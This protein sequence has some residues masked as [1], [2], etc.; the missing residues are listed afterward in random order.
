MMRDSR[1]MFSVFDQQR[2]EIILCQIC[3]GDID[4]GKVLLASFVDP[5]QQIFIVKLL[6]KYSAVYCT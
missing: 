1:R 3:V 5:M 6:F 2:L 4:R